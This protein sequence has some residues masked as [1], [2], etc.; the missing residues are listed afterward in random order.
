MMSEDD[1]SNWYNDLVEKAGLC[2]KRYPIKGMNIWTAYGW[3]VMS[4]VDSFTRAE[5]ERTSHGEV[6][7]P[8]LIPEDQFAREEKHIKGFGSEVYWVTHAG[9]NPLD[10]KLVVRPTSETAMYPIFSLWV[11]A[12]TDLPLKVYQM[13]NVFRYETKQTRAF[14]RMREIHFFE[15]HTCHADYEDAERQMA[16]DM[17]IM[18]NVSKALCLP[19]FKHRRPDWDKFAGAHYSVGIDCYMPTGRTVQIGGIH[20]YRDNFAKAYD[21]KYEAADGEH[22][23]VHQTTYGMS[24]RLV[25]AIVAVH[26]DEKG[27]KLPPAVAPIQVVIVPILAK[28]GKDDV[29]GE[30]EKVRAELASAGVRVHLDDRDLRPGNKYYDWELKGVPLRLELGGRDIKSQSVLSVRRDTREKAPIARSELVSGVRAK[31]DAIQKAMWDDAQAKLAGGT[32]D[33]KSLE[34]ELPKAVLRMAW[35]G[36]NACGQEIEAQTGLNI[37]GT[38]YRGEACEGSCVKCGSAAKTYLYAAKTY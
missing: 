12:H 13:C 27:L 29:S 2:D 9:D 19:H 4:L 18:D 32:V 20:Q 17:E 3:K 15:A 25:G 6:C 7:F 38:S 34:G 8:L 23:H 16:Q 22:R 26:G 30:C 33:V 31:L 28:D 37:L 36:E 21:I 10:V 11:R 35:C 5:M 1:F 14:M 24:E